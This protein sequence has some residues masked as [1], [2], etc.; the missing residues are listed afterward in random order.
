MK[1]TEEK[2]GVAMPK[3]EKS[4]GAVSDNLMFTE[5]IVDYVRMVTSLIEGR[6][7]SREEILQMLKRVVRQHSLARERRIDYILR[8]LKEKPP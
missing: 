1:E 3:E 8:T 7:V 6:P 2:T 5:G 4:L